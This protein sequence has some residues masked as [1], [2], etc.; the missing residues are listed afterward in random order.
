MGRDTIGPAQALTEGWRL[1]RRQTGVLIGGF[2]TFVSLLMISVIIPIPYLNWVILAAI[3]FPLL[4][5]LH[6]VFLKAARDADPRLVDLFS[7]FSQYGKWFDAG[8]AFAGIL[9]LFVFSTALAVS[10]AVSWLL[11]YLRPALAPAEDALGQ[12]LYLVAMLFAAILAMALFTGYAFTLFASTDT[13]DRQQAVAKSQELARGRRVRLLATFSAILICLSALP[14]VGYVVSTNN[15]NAFGWP[16][17]AA[18]AV[19]VLV[20]T[21][22]ALCCVTAVYVRL[23]RSTPQPQESQVSAAA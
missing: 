19:G 1:F 16:G 4:G 11:I 23:D 15:A 18:F 14:V 9:A 21:V 10:V 2:V 5:G 7:G 8:F 12:H 17:W 22:F 13:R 20:T 3:A 6:V